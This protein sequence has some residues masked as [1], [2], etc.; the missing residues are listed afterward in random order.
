MRYNL[1]KPLSIFAI[2]TI[3]TFLAST[4]A[5]A[6][7]HATMDVSPVGYW[8]TIDEK[9]NSPKG[10]MHIYA[11]KSGKLIGKV[12]GGFTKV[13]SPPVE[14]TCSKCSD[15]TYDASLNYGLKKD[16]V[17]LGKIIMW[18][19]IKK[20]NKWTNGT[21][22]DTSSGK[23]Y[24]SDIA[25]ASTN[26]KINPN[27]L[28]VTGKVFFFSRTQKWQRVPSLSA[29]NALCANKGAKGFTVKCVSGI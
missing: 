22:I 14:G 24:N 13:G 12:I 9:T 25:L 21:I 29:L 19:Y 7:T 15:K 1:I 16:E 17:K 27:I 26:G 23:K 18:N 8:K 4:A 11:D 28:D 6:D 2:S 5:L 20:G 3:T 10:L